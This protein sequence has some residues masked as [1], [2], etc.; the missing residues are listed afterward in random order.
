MPPTVPE[1]LVEWDR[2]RRQGTPIPLDELC[3]D[4]P[5]ALPELRE[6]AR[7]LEECD[8]LLG[9]TSPPLTSD[10]ESVPNRIGEYEIRGILGQGGMGVVY[11]GWDPWLKRAVAVKVLRPTPAYRPF[12]RP[13]ELRARFDRERV[14]LGLLDHDHLVPVYGSGTTSDDRPYFVMALLAGGSARDRAADL[15]RRGPRAVAVF[16]AKVARGVHA[17]H[18]LGVLHRDLKPANILLTAAGEP[19]VSDFGLA[20]FWSPEAEAD[21]DQTWVDGRPPGPPSGDLTFPG[22][23]PGTPAYMAPEQFNP[24]RGRVGPA[25]DIW[26]LGVVL[27]ELISGARPFAAPDRPLTTQVCTDPTPRCRS[28]HGR[29]PRWLRDVVNRCLAKDP[30]D[31]FPSAA[32]LADA[33]ERG[34]RAGRQRAWLAGTVGVLVLVLAVGAMVGRWLRPGPSPTPEPVVV[35]PFEELPE[36]QQALADLAAGKEVVLIDRQQSAPFRWVWDEPTGSVGRPPGG[37]FY[38][39]SIW[40]GPTPIEFLPWL[41]PGRYRVRARMRHDSGDTMSRVALYVDGRTWRSAA[42]KHLACTWLEYSDYGT[43]AT[44]TQPEEQPE[45]SLALLQMV[46][47]TYV[48]GRSLLFREGTPWTAAEHG[49]ALIRSAKATGQ[50]AGIRTI[51]LEIGNGP[52]VGKMETDPLGPMRAANFEAFVSDCRRRLPPTED[53]GA[54]NAGPVGGVGL[55]I[56]NG[57]VSVEDLRVIPISD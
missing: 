55:V 20:R 47:D 28:P 19:R 5:D 25:T 46:C 7:R 42:G 45:Y 3:V 44:P 53:V 13:T 24:G 49:R 57:V 51:E 33:L 2:R 9:L 21:P 4:S 43:L 56:Y 14:V 32:A 10:E 29:V 22:V 15:T 34:L 37:L 30:A 41:P 50:P 38:L 36:V 11:R 12:V 54:R 16:M 35:T 52:T 27:Y 40:S 26:A 23:Q 48:P 6:R 17:A 18:A 1:M 31:R 39:Y 8:R